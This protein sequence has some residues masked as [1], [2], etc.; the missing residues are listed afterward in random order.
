MQNQEINLFSRTGLII[1]GVITVPIFFVVIVGS[2]FPGLWNSGVQNLG[3]ARNDAP[4]K[5]IETQQSQ[6]PQQLNRTLI[7]VN[8]L[9]FELWRDGNCVVAKGVTTDHLKALGLDTNTFKTEIKQ[10]N[11]VRCVLLE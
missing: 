9:G 2:Y 4:S 10:Q 1:L 6:A 5:T 7:G 8:Q 11:N 3:I